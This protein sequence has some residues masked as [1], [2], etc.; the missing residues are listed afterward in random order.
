DLEAVLV[1]VMASASLLRRPIDLELVESAL[2]KLTPRTPGGALEPERVADLVAAHFQLPRAALA[3]R[4][5][6][7]DVLLPRQIAMYL[8]T[9]HTDASLERIGRAF[10]RSHPAVS[11]AVRAVKRALATRPALRDRIAAIVSEI[12][13][14][15]GATRKGPR[16]AS[17]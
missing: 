8:C 2:R 13:A 17:R 14:L 1:Q 9:Q 3:S 10:G 6:R 7:K 5:R 11:N 15:T 16:R 12:E 4:S